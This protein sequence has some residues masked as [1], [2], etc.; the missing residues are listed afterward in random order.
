[1]YTLREPT[2]N[3]VQPIL[4]K[5]GIQVPSNLLTSSNFFQKGTKSCSDPAEEVTML[6]A[7]HHGHSH[8]EN[9]LACVVIAGDILHN[10]TDGLSVGAAFSVSRGAGLACATAV[11]CHE[12]PHELGNHKAQ[13]IST[14]ISIN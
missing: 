12:L 14:N 5:I 10:V 8:T 2:G 9:P 13:S 4:V 6:D 7:H 3:T 11:F 1:M